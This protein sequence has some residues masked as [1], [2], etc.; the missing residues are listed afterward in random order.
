MEY[1][2][3]LGTVFQTLILL[4]ILILDYDRLDTPFLEFKNDSFYFTSIY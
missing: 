2:G 1:E 4:I 3:N